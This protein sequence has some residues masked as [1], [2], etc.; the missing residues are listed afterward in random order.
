M[1]F[2]GVESNAYPSG[3]Y[4]SFIVYS[5]VIPPFAAPSSSTYS[6]SPSILNTP[7]SSVAYVSPFSD[8]PSPNILNC[9]PDNSISSSLAYFFNSKLY[10]GILLSCTSKLI[11]GISFSVVIVL[12]IYF[13]TRDS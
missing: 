5:P 7:F 3:A 4:I 10:V 13:K 11:V 12:F 8:V 1:N 2:I 9:A 6:Y